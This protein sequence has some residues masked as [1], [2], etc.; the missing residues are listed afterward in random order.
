MENLN[1]EDNKIEIVNG[2]GEELNISNV[3]S[4]L[5][6]EKP[7]I[8]DNANKKIIIPKSKK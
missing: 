4:H 6:I 7:R 3:D 5:P 2:T 8:V 1:D